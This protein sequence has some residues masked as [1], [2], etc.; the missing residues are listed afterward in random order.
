MHNIIIHVEKNELIESYI[1]PETSE[2]ICK[3]GQLISDYDLIPEVFDSY[4]NQSSFESTF[5]ASELFDGD[6]NYL[7]GDVLEIFK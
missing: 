1:D 2:K 5:S 3:I 7:A 6:L 4:S